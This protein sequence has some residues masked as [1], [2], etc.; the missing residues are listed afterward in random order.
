MPAQMPGAAGAAMP[1]AQHEE[2]DM[3]VG[4]PQA[5][6]AAGGEIE[7]LRLAPDIG[8]GSRDGPAGGDLFGCPQ[9]LGHVSRP[10]DH[11]LCRIE[12]GRG[13]AR[14]IGQAQL[15][16]IIAQL[17]VKNSG[18]PGGYKAFSLRQGKAKA[19]ASIA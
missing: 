6:A 19:G 9:E 16:G 11:Q 3:A 14:P 13:E 5:E 7:E 10:H 2:R 15:L 4:R 12:P 17:Q 1:V 18:T 8:H